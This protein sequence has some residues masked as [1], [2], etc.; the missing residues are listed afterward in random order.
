MSSC[1]FTVLS[2]SVLEWSDSPPASPELLALATFWKGELGLGT[3]LAFKGEVGVLTLPLDEM[4]AAVYPGPGMPPT[5]NP[6]PSPD[7]EPAPDPLPRSI[8]CLCPWPGGRGRESQWLPKGSLLMMEKPSYSS[9]SPRPPAP[10]ATTFPWGDERLRETLCGCLWA[11]SGPPKPRPPRWLRKSL[12]DLEAKL[13][14][15]AMELK[16]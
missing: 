8:R 7:P 10:P 16:L 11:D 9:S 2:V 13:M 3:R 6:N 12:S 4:D 14:D 1:D 5:P 15:E